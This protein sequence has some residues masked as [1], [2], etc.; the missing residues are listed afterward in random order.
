M[1]PLIQPFAI[2]ILALQLIGL[3]VF[4]QQETDATY[5]LTLQQ[6]QDLAVENNLMVENS[7]LDVV[8]MR[9]RTREILT[10]GLPQIGGSVKYTHNFEL[11]VTILPGELAG[12]PGEDIEVTFGTEHNLDAS[13]ELQQLIVDGRYFVGLKANRSFMELSKKQL[14]I[15]ENDLR[16]TIAEAYYSVLVVQEG[17]K[18]LSKNLETLD[19]VRFGTSEMYKNGFVEELD[20]DRLDLQ[21]ANLQSKLNDMKARKEVAELVLCYNLG[22]PLDG[23]L[24]LTEDLDALLLQDPTEITATEFN[25][26]IR[27]EYQLLNIQYDIRGF[28]ASQLRAGYYPGL[29]AFAAYGI[30]AQRNEFNFFETNQSWFRSG[31]WGVVLTVPIYD[32]HRKAFQV[33]QRKLDQLKIQN[34]IDNFKRQAQLEVGNAK[35]DYQQ[36]LDNYNIQKKNLALAEKI[37]NTVNTKHQEGLSTSLDVAIAESDLTETQTNYINSMYNLLVTKNALDKALGKY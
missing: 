7:E 18:V 3:P 33:Q 20:V 19:R 31:S 1:Q 29:A 23:N 13:V 28:D 12:M 11:P 36:A 24:V 10:E 26:E 2:L 16:Y 35:A 27:L 25:P 34:N 6:A 4:S 30:N 15:T 9:K 14:D 22:I 21:I 5:T 37:F 32:S 8:I 17:Y